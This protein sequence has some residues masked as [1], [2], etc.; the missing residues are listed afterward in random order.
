MCRN[1]MVSIQRACG[2]MNVD[3]STAANS[4]WLARWSSINKAHAVVNRLS[5]DRPNDLVSALRAS[6][7]HI[8]TSSPSRRRRNDK[9]GRLMPQSS[10]LASADLTMRTV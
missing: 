10:A 6:A 7:T 1:W 5:T 9:Q 4:H 2:A 8:A 3:Q